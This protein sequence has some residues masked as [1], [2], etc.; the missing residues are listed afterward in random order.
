[1]NV[2]KIQNHA[3]SITRIKPRSQTGSPFNCLH[4]NYENLVHPWN[5]IL[6]Q[7]RQLSIS[8]TKTTTAAA[9]ATTHSNPRHCTRHF[10]TRSYHSRKPSPRYISIRSN[11]NPFLKYSYTRQFT[12]SSI[13]LIQNKNHASRLGSTRLSTKHSDPLEV[14]FMPD[15]LSVD[16][17]VDYWKV[18]QDHL[19]QKKKIT[20]LDLGRLLGWLRTRDLTKDIAFKIEKIMKEMDSRRIGFN[21]DAYNDLAYMNIKRGKFQ[22][23]K[24]ILDFISKASLNTV[25]SQRMLALQIAMYFK[26]GD[27]EALQE[28]L[29]GNKKKLMQYMEQFLRWT[30]GLQLTGDQIERVR[31][32]FYNLQTENCLPNSRRFTFLLDS[33]FTANKPK[34]ALALVNHVLDIGFKVENMTLSAVISGLLNAKLFEETVTLWERVSGQDDIKVDIVILNP[35]LSSLSRDPKRFPLAIDLWENILEDARIKP[36]SVSFS[37]MLNGYFRSHDATHALELWNN[38]QRSPFWIKPNAIL[39]HVMISGL[40]YNHQPVKAKEFFEDMTKSK[41]IKVSLDSYNIMAKGLASIKDRSGLKNIFGLM[42]KSGIKPDATT[43]T[44]IADTLFSQGDGASALKITQLMSDLGIPIS[45]V[46]YSAMVAG[47]V[48]VGDWGHAKLVYKKMEEA[49]FLPSIHTYGAMMQ[50]ALKAGDVD[51]AEEMAR[52]AKTKIKEGMSSAAYSIM[53]SGYTELLMLDKAEHWLMEQKREDRK[54]ISWK[55]YFVLLKACVDH[56]RWDHAEKVLAIM[57]ECGFQ[58]RIPR[59]SVL[60]ESV[61]QAR[62]SNQDQAIGL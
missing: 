38:M 52:L 49:K 2:A 46:T 33:L 35:I 32:R 53:I 23:A 47:L 14:G 56:Q 45:E 55:S 27:Q 43:Y 34:E 7:V 50:G 42:E 41:D 5:Y 25:T 10:T 61:E 17:S 58:S 54:S 21:L 20:D 22:D 59:L 28:I 24:S 48:N 30:K 62:V 6:F 15:Y 12:R 36:D 39:Y 8:T 60:I 51:T 37:S 11:H 44:I 1:M 4:S 57:K 40:F 26:N 18:Y 16:P 3:K 9:T 13:D 19:N 29:E 31:S